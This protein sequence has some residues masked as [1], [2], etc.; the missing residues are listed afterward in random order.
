LLPAVA[1]VDTLQAVMGLVAVAQ[2]DLF[3]LM[4]IL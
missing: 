3:I 4:I 1:V 2:V